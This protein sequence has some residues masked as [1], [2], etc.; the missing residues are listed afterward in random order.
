MALF[1]RGSPPEKLR[2]GAYDD[3]DDDEVSSR[4]FPNNE[5]VSL[6]DLEGH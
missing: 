5:M 2:I 1:N 3:D 4:Q 6:E